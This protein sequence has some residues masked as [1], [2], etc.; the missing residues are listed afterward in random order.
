MKIIITGASG[1]VGSHLCERLVKLGHNV[2][3]IAG[4]NRR[5]SRYLEKSKNFRLIKCD[6]T[7]TKKIYK[8]FSGNRDA[9]AVFHL[10]ALRSGDESSPMEWLKTNTEG[11]ASVLYAANKCGIKSIIYASTMNVYGKVRYLPVNEKHPA[12]PKNFYVICKLH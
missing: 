2:V 5:D 1:F 10:A 12:E 9:K 11:T 6:I 8:V 7:N 4:K 3:G